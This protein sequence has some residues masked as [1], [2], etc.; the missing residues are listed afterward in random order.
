MSTWFVYNTPAISAAIRQAMSEQAL[1][2]VQAAAVPRPERA[3]PAS[4]HTDLAIARQEIQE[5]KREREALKHRLQL[6]LGAEIDNAVQPE[7]V[8]K[9][10]GLE[11]HTQALTRDLAEARTQAARLTEQQ[12]ESDETI[13]SLRLTLR[14]AMRTLP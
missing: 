13:A 10:Q 3:I 8:Q 6:A 2:G 5:L 7:L 4:L 9:V 11:R 12:Q 1:H 14:K